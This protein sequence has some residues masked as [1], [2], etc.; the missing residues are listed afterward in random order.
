M[1]K[2]KIINK[3]DRD[4]KLYSA[5]D[6][7]EIK[8]VEHCKKFFIIHYDQNGKIVYSLAKYFTNKSKAEKRYREYVKNDNFVLVE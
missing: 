2:Y 3:I 1:M 8:L 5:G 7:H 6:I 4:H